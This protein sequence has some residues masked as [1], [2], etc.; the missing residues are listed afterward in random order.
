MCLKV[1]NGGTY[2]FFVL[3]ILKRDFAAET[4]LLSIQIEIKFLSLCKRSKKLS[5]ATYIL[6]RKLI[7]YV[8]ISNY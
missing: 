6:K 5:M 1:R 3:N 2:C 4:G 8:L 7:Q